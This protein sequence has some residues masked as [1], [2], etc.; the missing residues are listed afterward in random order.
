[1]AICLLTGNAQ[2]HKGAR[3]AYETY[4]HG[5]VDYVPKLLL[6]DNIGEE[7]RK[8]GPCAQGNDGQI[9][10]DPEGKGKDIAHVGLVQGQS[11]A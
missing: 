3:I 5:H 11:E 4:D 1:M 7:P 6:T 2:E 9:K 8:K 10:D